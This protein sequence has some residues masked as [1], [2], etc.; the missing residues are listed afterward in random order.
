MGETRQH[1]QNVASGLTRQLS[2]ELK[3]QYLR[4]FHEAGEFHRSHVQVDN[5]VSVICGSLNTIKTVTPQNVFSHTNLT[6]QPGVNNESLSSTKG[7][8]GTM[9]P[10]FGLGVNRGQQIPQLVMR[11]PPQP[12]LGKESQVSNVQA[13]YTSNVAKTEEFLVKEKFIAF[14][15]DHQLPNKEKLRGKVYCK[16]HNS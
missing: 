12:D 7:S 1:K 16:Y 10:P 4:N 11:S 13:Q 2:D 6:T 15:Q 5:P 14:P 9:H 3:G 8:G